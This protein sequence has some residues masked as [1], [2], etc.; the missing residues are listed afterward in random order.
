MPALYFCYKA[1]AT[2]ADSV[3]ALAYNDCSSWKLLNER[4]AL[5]KTNLN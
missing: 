4:A 1:M 3:T 2:L 5:I